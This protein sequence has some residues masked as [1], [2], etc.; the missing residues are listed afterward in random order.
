MT[1]LMCY[2]CVQLYVYVPCGQISVKRS[3]MYEPHTYVTPV[4]DMK[5]M[6]ITISGTITVA[7]LFLS[8]HVFISH[9]ALRTRDV[10]NELLIVL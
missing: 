8:M 2:I 6:Q 3:Y 5:Y 10:R 9:I 4:Q 1:R 7:N